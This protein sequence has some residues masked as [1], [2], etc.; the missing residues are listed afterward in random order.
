MRLELGSGYSPTPGFVHVDINASAP[1]VDIV[2]T[3]LDLYVIED[4]AV[5]EIRA[6]D[7]LE[8]ISYRDTDRA[9]AE[10]A[11]VL[12]PGGRL[13][14]QVPDAACV[15]RWWAG[16]DAGDDDSR[17][18]LI[19][20]LPRDLPRTTL[21]GVSWR[22]LGGHLDGEYAKAGDDFR[23]NAHYS[24]WDHQALLGALDAVGL[25]V[26]SMQTNDHPNIQCH[27]IKR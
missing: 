4:G 5:T 14:V 22:L 10:W 18:A 25:D 13:F 1:H 15:M 7:V 27:A 8:H 2:S 17:D 12:R 6:V 3:A 24:L 11:R 21:A 16:A 23:W 20:R 19:E 9:L 26:E